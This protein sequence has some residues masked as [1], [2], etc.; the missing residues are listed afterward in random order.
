[1]EII[2]IGD[3]VTTDIK[4]DMQLKDSEF[5]YSKNIGFIKSLLKDKR[6]IF[7]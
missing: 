4:A 6:V 3:Q 7:S 2:W 5:D 1:M